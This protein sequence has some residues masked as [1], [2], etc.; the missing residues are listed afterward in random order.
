MPQIRVL[1]VEDEEL[2]RQ[3]VA[4]TLIEAGFE[5][6]EACNGEA[7]LGLLQER[8]GFDLLL[9]D[10]HM[11]GRLNGVDVARHMRSLWPEIP[12][13]FVT[14]RPDTL[15][16]FGSPG[17]RDR[18]VLKPYRPTDAL[19]AIRSSLAQE[20]HGGTAM[21]VFPYYGS[22]PNDTFIDRTPD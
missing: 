17:P 12:V 14:G 19:A 18:C 8:H 3:I 4:E 11:P 13:V 22:L 9:T 10:V 7:A 1:F 21:P 2:I 6:T 5:V 20:H 15:H 16:A